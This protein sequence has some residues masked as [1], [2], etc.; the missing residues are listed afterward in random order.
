MSYGLFLAVFA[1]AGAVLLGVLIVSDSV[2]AMRSSRN[3]A[4][5]ATAG[6]F[7]DKESDQPREVAETLRRLIRRLAETKSGEGVRSKAPER[8]GA[9]DLGELRKQIEEF[10]EKAEE[11]VREISEGE[12][13]RYYTVLRLLRDTFVPKGLELRSFPLRTYLGADAD[14]RASVLQ[15]MVVL[16]A[17]R[18]A[19]VSGVARERRNESGSE[20]SRNA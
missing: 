15:L 14:T 5:V 2:A 20:E 6:E 7:G 1:G 13:T 9:G 4:V 19:D 8:E 16:R 17:L 3:L 12:V 18:E 11:V 10:R